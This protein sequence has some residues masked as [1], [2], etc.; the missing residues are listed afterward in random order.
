MSG[1][2]TRSDS[3]S[4]GWSGILFMECPATDDPLSHCDPKPR[5]F[6]HQAPTRYIQI[7]QP[8]ADEQLVNILCEPLA[9]NFRR[10]R[11]NTHSLR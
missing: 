8:V 9:L 1:L 10:P 5:C 11:L 2:G 4:I 7:P 3:I 6:R